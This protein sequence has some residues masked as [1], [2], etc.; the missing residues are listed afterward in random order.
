MARYDVY[1]DPRG[2]ENLLVCIQS[3]IF[4]VIDT[5]V[6]IPLLPEHP[7][8]TALKKLNPIIVIAGRNYAL[9]TQLLLSVPV[10]ALREHVANIADSRDEITAALDMLFQGF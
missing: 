8:R 1:R 10:S 7:H 5:R 9:Y 2:S 6:A 4:D 3:D